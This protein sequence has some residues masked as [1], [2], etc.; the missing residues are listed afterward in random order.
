MIQKTIDLPFLMNHSPIQQ[1]VKF[2]ED[3]DL[4]TLEKC[5]K[6]ALDG[7]IAMKQTEGK[8]LALDVKRRLASMKKN[9][10]AIRSPGAPCG[11]SDAEKPHGKGQRAPGKP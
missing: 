11:S 3:R 5:L 9:L 1:K 2:A 8:A 4:N 6:E 7:C 10:K